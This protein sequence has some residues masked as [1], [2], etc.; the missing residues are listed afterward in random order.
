MALHLSSAAPACFAAA[1]RGRSRR[2]RAVASEGSATLKKAEVVEEEKVKLGG[3][4]LKVTRLGIGAWSWGDTSYWNNFQWDD[5]KM[6][7]AKGAFDSSIDSGITLFDT[8]EVYGS[9]MSF[10]AINSETLLGSFAMETGPSECH[11]CP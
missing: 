3:S 8:A 2:A 7:A 4:D 10:G 6:K 1:N 9:R 11:Y 5:R